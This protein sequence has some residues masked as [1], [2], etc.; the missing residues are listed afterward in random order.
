MS[1][2]AMLLIVSL[3][4]SCAEAPTDYAVQ[5]DVGRLCAAWATC[6]PQSDC[7]GFATERG[8]M[9]STWGRETQSSL[10]LGE[11][12]AVAKVASM[13]RKSGAT[14]MSESCRSLSAAYP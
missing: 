10:E 3:L 6:R 9:M 13:A 11:A 4:L 14:T 8:R 5:H 1:Q 12:G 7:S 2:I